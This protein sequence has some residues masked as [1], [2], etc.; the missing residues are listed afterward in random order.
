MC[1]LYGVCRCI[2]LK[3]QLTAESA[4]L[5]HHHLTNHLSNTRFC[6]GR[7]EYTLLE[8]IIAFIIIIL[9]HGIAFY[10]SFMF[11]HAALW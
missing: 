8:F 4:V 1:L 9:T 3:V 10:T 6:F 2:D 5:S 7:L 11:I